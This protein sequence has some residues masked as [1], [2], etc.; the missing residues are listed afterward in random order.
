MASWN[1]RLQRLTGLE[2]EKIQEEMT[3]VAAKIREL[4]E[5]LASRPR[6]MEVMRDELL[7]ARAAIDSPRMTDIIDAE[8]QIRTM[9]A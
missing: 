2:R 1:L 5:I 9:R 4:L 6:R 3:E 7:K 8:W